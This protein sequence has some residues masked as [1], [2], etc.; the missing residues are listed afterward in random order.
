L[1][2]IGFIVE[3]PSDARLLRSQNFTQLLAQLHLNMVNIIVPE[4][5]THF[6]HPKA[7]LPVLEEKVSSFISRLKAQGAA[8]IIFLVDQDTEPC[9]TAVKEKIPF[10]TQNTVIIC[11]RALEAWF[12]AD[13]KAMSSLLKINFTFEKPEEEVDPFETIRK[14]LVEKTGRGAGDKITLANRVMREGF[15]I[16]NAAKHPGC[17]SARYFL[18]KLQMLSSKR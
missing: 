8:I 14:V 11:K 13:E 5:K 3:G 16:Q 4:G 9:F 1:V 7:E 6:W 17:G 2:N 15:D 10:S 12:L 18:Q